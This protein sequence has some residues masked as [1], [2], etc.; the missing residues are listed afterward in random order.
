MGSHPDALFSYATT[1]YHK[2]FNEKNFVI[3]ENKVEALKDTIERNF[4]YQNGGYTSDGRK[5]LKTDKLFFYD[6]KK[7]SKYL[8]LQIKKILQ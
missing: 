1:S 7:I 2:Y 3:Y 4:Y 5:W 6:F 8:R